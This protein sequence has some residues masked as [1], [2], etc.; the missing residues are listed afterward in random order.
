MSQI[1]KRTCDQAFESNQALVIT[2]HVFQCLTLGLHPGCN[3][4]LVGPLVEVPVG[5]HVGLPAGLPVGPHF[6]ILVGLHGPPLPGKDPPAPGRGEV[7][8]FVAKLC[9]C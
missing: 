1:S 2:K 8:G 3:G 6:G 7:E 5:L 9:H 4:L